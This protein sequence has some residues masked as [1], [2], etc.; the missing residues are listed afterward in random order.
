MTDR[1]ALWQ[2]LLHLSNGFKQPGG[3]ELRLLTAVEKQRGSLTPRQVLLR[4]S[5]GP[6]QPEV[7]TLP[8]HKKHPPAGVKATTRSKVSRASLCTPCLPSTV[9]QQ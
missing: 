4:L 7:V 6:E 5:N 3:V 1:V 9:Y 2:L 8:K